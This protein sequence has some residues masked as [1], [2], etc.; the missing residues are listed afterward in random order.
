M[1]QVVTI[2]K[3]FHNNRP[4]I[5]KRLGVIEIMDDSWIEDI[6]QN[7]KKSP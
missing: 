6:K 7:G 1:L 4:L 3:N 2:S 5:I